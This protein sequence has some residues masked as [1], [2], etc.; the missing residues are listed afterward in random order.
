MPITTKPARAEQVILFSGDLRR[1]RK[2][3]KC[4]EGHRGAYLWKSKAACLQQELC[5]QI[6]TDM[7]AEATGEIKTVKMRRTEAFS[8]KFHDRLSNGGLDLNFVFT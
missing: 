8:F 1:G 5:R 3:E 7:N 6:Q 4:G 2:G